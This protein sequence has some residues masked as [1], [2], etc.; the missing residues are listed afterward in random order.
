M[1]EFAINSTINES[2]GF[3]P[4]ELT[5]GNMLCIVNHIDPTSY[6]HYICSLC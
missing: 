5:Y 6:L 4:L 1:V 3:A 2:A